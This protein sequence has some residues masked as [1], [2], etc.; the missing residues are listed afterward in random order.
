M[1]SI[2]QIVNL[3][4]QVTALSIADIT[5]RKRSRIYIRARMAVVHFAL[6]EGYKISHIGAGIGGRDHSTCC[7]LRDKSAI[8]RDRD[9]FYRRIL[10]RTAEAIKAGRVQVFTITFNIPAPPVLTRDEVAELRVRNAVR[11]AYQEEMA[12]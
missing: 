8:Y 5:G 11:A 10:L 9:P 1:T 7:N 12:A 4:A 6:K 2:D 3:V